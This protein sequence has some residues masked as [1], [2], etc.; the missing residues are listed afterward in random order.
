MP[1]MEH[2]RA[3]T[4]GTIFNIDLVTEEVVRE[5]YEMSLEKNYEAQLKRK[6]VPPPKPVHEELRNLSST[7]VPIGCSGIAPPGL[8]TWPLIS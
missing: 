4:L 6:G 3:L 7:D 1:S 8:T 2:I 5:R